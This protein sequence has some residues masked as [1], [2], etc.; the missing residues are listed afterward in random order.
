[1]KKVM[2]LVCIINLMFAVNRIWENDNV[3]NDM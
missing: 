1:M 2:F 3:R